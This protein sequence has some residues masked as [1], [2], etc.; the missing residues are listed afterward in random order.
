VDLAA[1][2]VEG[3]SLGMVDAEWWVVASVEVGWELVT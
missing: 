2:L 3:R 1:A